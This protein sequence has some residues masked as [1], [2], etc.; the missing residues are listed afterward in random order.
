MVVSR[1]VECGDVVMGNLS[2]DFEVG[3]SEI[4]PF[5]S[6][7]VISNESRNVSVY[8]PRVSERVIAVAVLATLADDDDGK[9]HRYNVVWSVI[10]STSCIAV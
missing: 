10:A 5:E 6:E 8:V 7:Q 1:R 3:R 4:L 2:A 9:R